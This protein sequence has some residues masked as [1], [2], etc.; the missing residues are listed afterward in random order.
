MIRQELDQGSLGFI[1]S[2]ALIAATETLIFFG[3]L[4]AAVTIHAINLIVLVLSAAYIENEVYLVLMF[5][6]I[7]R[8]LNQQC[9]CSPYLLFISLGPCPHVPHNVLDNKQKP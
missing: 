5:L 8:L 1:L 7:F 6:P 3:H 9:L 4:S 2:A